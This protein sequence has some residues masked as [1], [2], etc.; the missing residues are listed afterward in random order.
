MSNKDLVLK[1]MEGSVTVIKDSITQT[2]AEFELMLTNS[3]DNGSYL[4][5]KQRLKNYL[6]TLEVFIKG[7]QANLEQLES[8]P[9]EN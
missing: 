8:L 9:Y 7:L 4:Y 3:Y 5:H 6:N 1:V 2:I